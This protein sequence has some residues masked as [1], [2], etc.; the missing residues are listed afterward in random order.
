V[1]GGGCWTFPLKYG[2]GIGAVCDPADEGLKS[3]NGDSALTFEM[4]MGIV[5]SRG[6]E[7]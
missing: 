4:G 3:D 5:I 2:L 1:I 7:V 6:T